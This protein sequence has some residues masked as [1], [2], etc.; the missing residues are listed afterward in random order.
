[1]SSADLS[2]KT[3][4]SR[5]KLW[6]HA[7][8]VSGPRHGRVNFLQLE[9]K[10]RYIVKSFRFFGLQ[11]GRQEVPFRGRR[12]RNF[13]ASFDFSFMTKVTRTVV[14]ALHM[15]ADNTSATNTEPPSC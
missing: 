4:G 2:Q 8:A 5:E 1:M 9:E 6:A 11:T 13:I 3:G 12:Y 7:E 10:A 14:G 15:L